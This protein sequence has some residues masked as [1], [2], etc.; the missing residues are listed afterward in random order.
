[1]RRGLQVLGH[2]PQPHLQ[3]LVYAVHPLPRSI[4]EYVWDYGRLSPS[5]EERYIRAILATLPLHCTAP[6]EESITESIIFLVKS[7]HNFLR[8]EYGGEVAV[9]SLRDVV[10]LVRIASWAFDKR[11][12][13]LGLTSEQKQESHTAFVEAVMFALLL[14]Y[15]LRL[16]NESGDAG[17]ASGS[18]SKF[19]RVLER[20]LLVHMS[21]HRVSERGAFR[22]LKAHLEEAPATAYST[23]WCDLSTQMLN[24]LG[25]YT[26]W[27]VGA[28]SP[29]PPGVAANQALSENLLLMIVSIETRIPLV[30]VGQPG[31]S[32]S[33]ALQIIRDRFS[34]VMMPL[35]LAKLGFRSVAVLSLIHI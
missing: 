11:Q 21:K 12:L 28:L 27:L 34:Q 23:W 33:L 7:A 20:D 24:V 14:V 31:S 17:S 22:T 32:K 18:R 25:S 8:R 16:G 2:A 30:V 6:Y 13:L 1:M 10:R 15:W 9:V 29:L 19:L 5:E 4:L 35:E 3:D 26:N